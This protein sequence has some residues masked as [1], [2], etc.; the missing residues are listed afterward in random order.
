[1]IVSSMPIMS[2]VVLDEFT[3]FVIDGVYR[4]SNRMRFG[5]KQL[6][7]LAL[8]GDEVIDTDYQIA[9]PLCVA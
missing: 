6:Q 8:M 4:L 5:A 7:L 3:V 9:D 1:M 2:A